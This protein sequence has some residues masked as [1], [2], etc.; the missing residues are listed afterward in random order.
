MRRRRRKN[1]WLWRTQSNE[2]VA[3]IQ[4]NFRPGPESVSNWQ[5]FIYFTFFGSAPVPCDE[6]LRQLMPS[7]PF[8]TLLLLSPDRP[9]Q[10]V[11][12]VCQ[13]A[14]GRP[15]QTKNLLETNFKHSCVSK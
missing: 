4:I 11:G 8:S 13:M 15:A 6:Q 3:G 12:V 5:E 1:C 9:L 2:K 10:L 14:S 7:Q